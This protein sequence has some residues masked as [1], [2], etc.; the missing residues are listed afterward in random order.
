MKRLFLCLLVG[1]LLLSS[2]TLSPGLGKIETQLYVNT[3]G[4]H[5][6]LPTE[7]QLLTEDGPG[8]V[9]APPDNDISLTIISELGGE[10]YY[11]LDE[12][13]DM[14]L[15]RLPSSSRPWQI[16]RTITN[17]RDK[18]RLSITGEDESGSEVVLDLS[19][20][21]PYPG[22]RYYLLFVAGH[23]AAAR[24]SAL[25]GDIV[26][27]FGMDEDLPYLYGLMEEWRTEEK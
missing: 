5:I 17:S 8:V 23:A 27:S 13:A 25:I 3:A 21:Q 10:A 6:T 24:Q 1:L 26:K 2:C 7:W 11:D 19:I 22:I 16:S 12:I 20:L 9:F 14:L 4:Y 15:E 18:L